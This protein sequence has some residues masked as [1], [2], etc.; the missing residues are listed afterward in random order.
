MNSLTA[1]PAISVEI[2]GAPLPTSA[3]GALEEVRVEQRL[4]LPA[5]CELTF[6]SPEP[7]FTESAL[8][9]HGRSLR[10]AVTDGQGPL[11]TG[12]ITAVEQSYTAAHGSTLRLRGYDRLHRLRK[13]QPLRVHVQTTVAELAGELTNDLGLTVQADADGPLLKRLLQHRQSDLDLLLDALDACGLFAALRGSVLHIFSL[14][15]LGEALPL[16][17]GHELLEIRLTVNGDSA[18]R[19][20]TASA[21]DP[22]RV[23]PHQGRAAHARSGRTAAAAAAPERFAVP[24][25]RRLTAELAEDDLQAEALAQ[26]ELDVRTAREV[27]FWAAAEGSPALL[28]GAR[29]TLRGVAP[30]L[31]GAH[32]L[33][34]VTHRIERATGFVS[35]LST[36]PPPRRPR[37]HAAGLALGVV[38]RVDDPEG[39]GR[40]RV[41]LPTQG[42]LETD[43][44]SVVSPG[45]GAGKGFSLLPDTGDQV[46]VL[47]AGGAGSHGIVLG[48]LYGSAHPPDSVVSSGAVT[49]YSL[50]THGGQKL[51]FDDSAR[52]LR[53]ED[54]AG[55][56]LEF[57]PERLML[58]SSVPL[59]IEAIGQPVVIRGK[60]IDFEE[61]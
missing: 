3:L 56:Y 15:G 29:V 42:D 24:G 46:A 49:R 54:P 14:E 60:T 55:N 36:E 45:A 20:V 34:A 35:E 7:A 44:M 61:S 25:E 38:T 30:T 6:T 2:D 52:S 39:L 28:P 53:L 33:T 12:E 51:V 22:A 43:W 48:G 40:I 10:V 8:A 23:E 4:S 5:L 31:A 32:V 41:S 59:Q 18:C 9:G 21:W 16:R 11:F 19:S 1:L 50:R 26:A 57:S 13:R 58:H 37:G 17:L 27:T 47:F